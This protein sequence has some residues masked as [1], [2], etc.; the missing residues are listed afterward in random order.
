MVLMALLALGASLLAFPSTARAL[1]TVNARAGLTGSSPIQTASTLPTPASPLT[2]CPWL[3]SA[4]ARHETPSALAA[5]VESRMTL[6]EKLGEL[7]LSAAGAYENVNRGVARLCIP[8]LTLQDGPAGLAF[9]DTGVTQL[10][11]PL[12]IAA[13]FDP[14]VA[15]QYGQVEGEEARGQGIDVVQGPNLNIDRVPESGR[16]FEG[17]GEDPLLVSAMGVA[18]IGGIQSQGVL[19][20]AK[21]LVTY[22]Q[23]TN[24]GALDTQVSSRALNEI[25]LAPFKAAVTQAHVASIMCAYPRLNGTFQCED[26]GLAQVLQ[27][28]GFS[29]FV[30]SDL[31]AVHDPAAALSAGTDLLKPT[32]VADLTAAVSWGSVPVAT[33]DADVERMLAQMFAYGL[34][35]QTS[36][37]V[38]GTP[39][40]TTAHAAFALSAAERSAVLLQNR[41]NLLPIDSAHI[42]SVAVIGADA[43]TAPVTAGFGSSHVVAPFTSAP[44][45]AIQGRLGANVAVQYADGGSTTRPLPGIP[46]VDLT[47][48]SGT[49]HGLTLTVGHSAAGGTSITSVDPVAAA[50]ID[51]APANASPNPDQVHSNPPADRSR[52]EGSADASGEGLS[53]DVDPSANL[54]TS[55]ELPHSWGGATAAWTGTLTPP[56][57]GLYSF[58]VTGSGSETLTLDGLNVVSDPLAHAQGTWSGSINL[59]A[60]HPYRLALNWVPVTDGLPVHN[61]LNLGMAYEGDAIAAAVTAARASQI[62]VVFAADYS[63]ETFDRPSLSLPGDQNA[64][65]SAVVAAN[66]NTVV[67]L[68]TGGP[69][70]MP[71]LG[72]V[73]SVV[74]AWYPGEQDG[75]AIAAVLCGDVNP[76]GH[77]PVTFPASQGQSAVPTAAQWP[78]TVLTSTYSEGLAVGYRFNNA[79]GI[80]PLFPFGFGLS[81][82][83]FSYGNAT[84]AVT[85]QGYRISVTVTNTGSRAGTDVAQAYLTFP[86][87][88]G[89]PP[90]QLVAFQPVSLAPGAT[91]TVTMTVPSSAFQVFQGSAWTTVPGTYTVGIGDSSESLATQTSL[92][93]G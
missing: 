76:S 68:N 71:W 24:R 79:T 28:W 42:R 83:T 20:D 38:P 81:Y 85:G 58:S 84:A 62:A 6:A 60:G 27:A 63:S 40:D 92:V 14:S 1:A 59:V 80:R 66:P 35:G 67:V 90:G 39:V 37:G 65:I 4:V 10:P 50:A 74:E 77:L 5:L 23:E 45:A 25:Y 87:G 69:V 22:S 13:T 52:N 61:V 51:V 73:A 34:V 93:I 2:S 46:T 49:G 12:G 48:A 72:S 86:A 89:E 18:D 41:S 36:T 57:T 75:A 82:T 9:G 15:R 33:I 47:P 31:G 43:S 56:R 8:S 26:P 78:G 32:S 88:S 7:A 3:A 21:H 70:L 11:A 29:G 55:I 19:A 54:G 91:Q 64:L 30:R 53:P 17:Y 44:L 16:A